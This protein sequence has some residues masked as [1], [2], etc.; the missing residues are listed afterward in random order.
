M[1]QHPDRS[2]RSSAD[3]V[4]ASAHPE[5]VTGDFH[6]SPRIAT[7]AP[8][9]LGL[10]SREILG[11]AGI[12]FGLALAIGTVAIGWQAGTHAQADAPAT[13]CQAWNDEAKRALAELALRGED[14]DLRQI[15]DAAFRMRRATRNCQAGWLTLACQDY[16]AVAAG[17]SSKIGIPLGIPECGKATRREA[18]N[19]RATVGRAP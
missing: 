14:S 9:G 11:I 16:R 10:S 3:F 1:H 2:M 6:L 8:A 4:R 18:D 12:A 13:E 7:P 15:G 5:L 19:G 17:A